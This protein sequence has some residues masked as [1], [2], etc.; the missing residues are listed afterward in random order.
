MNLDYIGKK[1]EKEILTKAKSLKKFVDSTDSSLLLKGDNFT[2]LSSLLPSYTGKVDL[3]Y[4]DPPFNTNQT[5]TVE[6]ERVSTIS[7]K[8]NAIVAYSDQM[9]PPEYIEF[10]RERLI[11]LRELLSENGSIYLHI[12]TK[13]GHYIKIIMDEIFGI[14][15]FKNDITRIKSNPKNF[16]RKAYGNQKDVIYFYAKNKDRNIFN[17]VTIQLDEN[18]KAKMFK[19][20]DENG[21]RYNTVPVHAPGETNGK[22][23]SEWRGML[24]PSGRHW[25]TDPS[26]LD[27]LDNLGLIEWSKNGVPRIKKFA[28]EH[29]GKKIQDIW[30]YID[31]AYPLYPTEKN[32]KMLEMIIEQSSNDD[33]I[34]L[35]CF[36]GSGS[37]LFAAQNLGRKWIGID[38]SD[39]SHRVIK[40]RFDATSYEY[41]DLSA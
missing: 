6:D 41:I 8:K 25:R 16:M 1:S 17:N 3:I 5:F 13:M 14:D 39:V 4:I 32:L 15:N 22:T 11:L 20:I 10:M 38:Q 36:A 28:D 18:D 24:P 2:A 9:T 30:N 12:D 27:K 37:T 19:K 34:I 23:G 40:K 35:D 21:R 26:E 7:R 33:S 31:P 29:K